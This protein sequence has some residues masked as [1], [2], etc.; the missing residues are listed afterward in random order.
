MADATK[1]YTVATSVKHDGKRYA[2]GDKVQL[3]EAQAN[4]LIDAGAIAGKKASAP[5]V[6]APEKDTPPA[7]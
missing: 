1:T 2:K 6:E 7:E 4:Q 3:T 5:K